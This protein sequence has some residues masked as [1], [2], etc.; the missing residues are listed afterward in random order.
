MVKR[1]PIIFTVLVLLFAGSV[2]L[3][4]QD[5]IM[6]SAET[7][8]PG[9]LKL[10]FFP[11]V[12]LG[13]NG[14]NSISG[15]AGRFGFALNPKTDIEGKVAFLKDLRYL[16]A[17]LE[18]WV[19][20]NRNINASVSVGGHL[21]QIEGETDSSGIDTTILISSKPRNNL[22]LC[23][24]FKLAF[25]SKSNYEYSYTLM[26]LVPGIEYKINKDLDFEAEF[27]I[28]LNDNT[29]SYISAGLAFY[30]QL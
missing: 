1:I 15:T 21:T 6:G 24:G 8:K 25:D 30:F 14:G 18:F 7:I 4:S 5:V 3:F 2:N 13:K 27:G 19:V 26:H 10:G 9:N 28:A 29:R 17:D 12:L 22:E 20:K 23:L 16:G 11:M